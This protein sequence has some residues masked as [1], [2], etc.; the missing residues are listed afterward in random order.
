MRHIATLAIL[1]LC[2]VLCPLATNPQTAPSTEKQVGRNLQVLRVSSQA[3][4][5]RNM[6][7][8]RA[9]LGVHCDYC[10]AVQNEQYS[11][12]SKPAKKKAREMI[13]MVMA[14]AKSVV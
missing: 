2:V 8:I 12:D 3:E 11:S 5:L 14:L 9:S 4:L 13:R 7:V 6:H 1:G 10:H